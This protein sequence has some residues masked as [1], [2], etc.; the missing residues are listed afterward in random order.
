[1]LSRILRRLGLTAALLAGA[2]LNAQISK[3]PGELLGILN[4]PLLKLPLIIQYQSTP[5]PL[6]ILKL[7]LLGGQVTHQYGLIPAVSVNLS[8][9]GLLSILTD[10]GILYI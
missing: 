4:Q 7:Q 1:M 5:G 2:T 10:P 8:V 6:D 3:L 9:S